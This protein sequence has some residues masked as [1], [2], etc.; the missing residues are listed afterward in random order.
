MA[1]LRGI[2]VGGNNLIKMAELKRC[3]ESLGF[4]DVATYIQSGNVLF[5]AEKS[6]AAQLAARV[7]AALA[8]TFGYAGRV[9]V[10]SHAQMSA[11]VD[12][13]PAGFG[14]EP[15]RYRYD[16]LFLLPPLTP[17]AAMKELK[18]REGV[19]RAFAGKGVCYFSRLV[20]RITQTYLNQIVGLPVYQNM[21]IRNWNTTAKL[22]ELLDARAKAKA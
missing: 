14:R 1:L 13:A 10:R 20:S 18:T 22:R 21:T 15:E 8:K 12:D 7:E 17:A 6:P 5:E 16:V 9:A 19:D 4:G 2:N 3:F 11:I